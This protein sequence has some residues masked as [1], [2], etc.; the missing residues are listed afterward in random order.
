MQPRGV[1]LML[2]EIGRREKVVVT[3]HRLRQTFAKT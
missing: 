3:P 2:Q 1:Q